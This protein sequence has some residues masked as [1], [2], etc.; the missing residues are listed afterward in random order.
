MRRDGWTGGRRVDIRKLEA[1]FLV[2]YLM[3]VL[4]DIPSMI[5]N[6]ARFRDGLPRERYSFLCL[7][8]CRAHPV[9]WVLSG[10]EGGLGPEEGTCA[11]GAAQ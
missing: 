3:V 10:G 1:A 4:G 2:A 7:S 8:L 6:E 9:D 11:N 5:D